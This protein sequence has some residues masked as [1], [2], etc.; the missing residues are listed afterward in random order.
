MNRVLLSVCLLLAALWAVAPAFAGT[1]SANGMLTEDRVISL[2][3]D[4]GKWYV[5]VVGNAGDSAY[6]GVL[7]W[8]DENKDLS[9][10]KNR[11]HFCQVA[12][13]TAIFQD[14]YATNV[15]TLPMVRVQKPD[16]TVIYEASG[17]NIPMTAEGLHGA[18]ASDINSAQGIRPILPWRRY[19]DKRPCPGPCPQPGPDT[20][21]VEPDPPPQPIDNGGAPNVDAP[22]AAAGALLGAV[23]ITVI[24]CCVALVVAVSVIVG[25][26]AA[27]K[28]GNQG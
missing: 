8:F 6:R 16:G 14:R 13:G 15:S 3:Q 28:R 20:Q 22:S 10:L 11:V 21:P 27:W 17:K 4:Q 7:R 12:T 9:S 24:A 1:A 2:P 5:S 26:V 18:I 23:G 25:A 19:I